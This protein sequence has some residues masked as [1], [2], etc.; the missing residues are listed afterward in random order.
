MNFRKVVFV[1]YFIDK[2]SVI[3]HHAYKHL[4]FYFDVIGG[5]SWP[6][7]S[8]GPN[9]SQTPSEYLKVDSF[10]GQNPY[11]IAIIL[12]IKTPKTFNFRVK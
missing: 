6:E 12:I 3:K 2:I 10:L 5:A 11:K 4:L 9:N 7:S 1:F 8:S